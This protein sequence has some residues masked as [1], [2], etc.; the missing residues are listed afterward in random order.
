M[1]LSAATAVAFKQLSEQVV[2]FAQSHLSKR[3]GDGQCVAAWPRRVSAIRGSE[4]HRGLRRHCNL[5]H[6]CLG[7][8]GG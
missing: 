1:G 8:S 7:R 3:V 5:G 4:D 6:F 2:K